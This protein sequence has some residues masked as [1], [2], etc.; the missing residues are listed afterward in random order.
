ML[1]RRASTAYEAAGLLKWT[2]R[3]HSLADLDLFNQVLA[4]QETV[5]HLEILVERGQTRR[6]RDGR[7]LHHEL[8][9]AV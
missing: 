8:H 9:A 2:R 6:L 7:V 4:V 1:A 5:A 3:E